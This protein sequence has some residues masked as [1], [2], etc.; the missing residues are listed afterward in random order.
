MYELLLAL[1]DLPRIGADY[2]PPL[3]ARTEQTFACG[4]TRYAISISRGAPDAIQLDDVAV[5]DRSLPAA[6][7]RPLEAALG[8]Y[9][10]LFGFT[11]D[12]GRNAE[13]L[14]LIWRGYLTDDLENDQ[15]R[16]A[17]GV[18]LIFRVSRDGAIHID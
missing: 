5:D 17:D 6:P 11:A 9:R 14:R 3:E 8:R 7:R 4:A 10:S 16:D 18:L 1:Q 13:E 12:C 2:T 15:E